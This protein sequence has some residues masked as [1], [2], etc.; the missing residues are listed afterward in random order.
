MLANGIETL[1]QYDSAGQMTNILRRRSDQSMISRYA[2]GYDDA[3]Q[4]ISV[5][6]GNGRGD[7][8]RYDTRAITKTKDAT[9]NVVERYGYDVYGEPTIYDAQSS[10]LTASA[11]GNRL[12]LQGR[13]LDPDTGLYNFRNRYYTPLSGA[14]VQVDPIRVNGGLNFYRFVE[15]EPVNASDPFGLVIGWLFREQ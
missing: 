4:R 10:I 7:V 6:R 12:L 13:D 3:G 8:E 5:L 15:N 11:I 2:Y 14:F 9:G 1:Y